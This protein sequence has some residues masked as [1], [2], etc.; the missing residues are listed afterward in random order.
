MSIS[1]I[2]LANGLAGATDRIQKQKLYDDELKRREEE[3]AYN[4]KRQEVADQQGAE[5]HNQQV[6]RNNLVIES[7]L[8]EQTEYNRVNE[9]KNNIGRLQQYKQVNDVDGAFSDSVKYMNQTN[10]KNPNWNQDHEFAY[11]RDYSNPEGGAVALNVV[12]RKT[13]QVVR[14][15]NNNASID[16]LIDMQYSQAKPMEIYES[17]RAAQ[18]KNAANKAEQAWEVQKMGIN[19]A[20]D[21]DKQNNLN[22][23]NG[24]ME[25]YKHNNT[26]QLEGLRQDGA[27]KREAMK[28][29]GKTPQNITVDGVFGHLMTQESNQQHIDPKTGKMT[30]SPVGAL[31]IAQIMPPTAKEILKETGI[32]V[33]SSQEANIAGGKYYLNKMMNKP[34]VGG[35]MSKALA[36]YNAGY[37]RLQAGIKRAELAGEPDQWLNYMPN[38]TQEYVPKIINGFSASSPQPQANTTTAKTT[39]AAASKQASETSVQKVAKS[40]TSELGIGEKTTASMIGG[41]SGLEPSIVKFTS[42][43]TSKGRAEAYQSI[44][45]MVERV[46]AKSEA[47]MAMNIRDRKE[48]IHQKAAEILGMNGKVEAGQWIIAGSS[49]STQQAKSEGEKAIDFSGFDV[50]AASSPSKSLPATVKKPAAQQN[51]ANLPPYLQRQGNSNDLSYSIIKGLKTN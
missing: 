19:H 51:K 50:I 49:G 15:I 13:G 24:K 30:R 11:T 9:I 29:S 42:N 27:N 20:Y 4:R 32:D 12:D 3:S 21:L 41:L 7:G 18:A 23:N 45:T 28:I 16:S 22:T 35:D 5:L 17:Q 44:L 39:K 36:A 10:S 25:Q 37:G 40:M 2:G 43:P 31:G 6:K 46:V 14:Q 1:F 34:L 48:Y 26:L 33:Y 47:G 38:E 8:N